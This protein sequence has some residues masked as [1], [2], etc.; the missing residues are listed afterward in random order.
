MT[1]PLEGYIRSERVGGVAGD[2]ADSGF[3][4]KL[5]FVNDDPRTPQV[6]T[7]TIDTATSGEDYSITIDGV[8]IT[9][10]AATSTDTAVA[11][12]LVDAVNAKQLVNGRVVATRSGANAI[13]TA[14]VGG[15][16]FTTAEG[17]NAAKMTLVN[18]TA[19]DDADLIP[20]GRAIVEDGL[21]ASSN[22][23]A[24]LCSA[25]NMTAQVQS[26]ALTY[27]ATV[28]ALVGVTVYDPATGQVATYEVEHTMATDAD[29]SVIALAGLLNAVLP[30]NTVV[31]GHTV[32]DTLDFTAEVAGIGF[33]LSYG[34]G[35]GRDTGAWV[36]TMDTQ[37]D[38]INTSIVGITIR[39][40]TQ[41]VEID[42][43]EAQYNA[44]EAMS[45]LRKGRMYVDIEAALTSVND[46]V[47]VRLAANGSLNELG[48]FAP[49]AGAGL[50]RWDRARWVR[51]VSSTLA[52]IEI[53][54]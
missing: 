14:R 12:Q 54:L 27:D 10:T 5:S 8:E 48:G 13:L 11:Q 19:D 49:A 40:H 41:E 31:V 52:I 53:D 29:A 17:D 37:G 44:N 1:S 38:D 6:D 25:A 33:E 32:A 45:A 28:S 34:F 43:E 30:A 42:A 20:F 35:T 50:Y 36:H 18:T 15:E 46:P 51:A 7:I 24:K 16:G 21:S 47:F 2:L 39:D 23:L 26:L 22:K 3:T 9:I 4:D